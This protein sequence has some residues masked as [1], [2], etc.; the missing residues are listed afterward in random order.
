MKRYRQGEIKFILKPDGS[1]VTEADIEIQKF[2]IDRIRK[3]FPNSG[4][5]AEETLEGKNYS[6]NNVTPALGL[7]FVIDPIDG[8]GRFIELGDKNFGCAIALMY[9]GE[10][11]AATFYAPEYEI[12]SHSSDKYSGSLFEASE[13]CDGMFL[14]GKPVCM[15]AKKTNFNNHTAVLED[16]QEHGLNL[17]SLKVIHANGS[18][19]LT[20]SLVSSGLKDTPIVLANGGWDGSP[21]AYLWDVVAGAY[22]I[23]K[24][25]GV[26]WNR[27]GDNFFPL[28]NIA[29][30][31][32]KPVY[33]GEYFTGYPNAIKQLLGV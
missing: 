5:I 29:L 20:L 30:H 24:A 27:H 14:N 18:D 2:I 9:N 3:E 10:V 25:G 11:I 32:G 28:T 23:E 15:D 8:T 22:F 17:D 6:T 7:N 12:N 21:G 16:V 13:L 31:K 1:K 19:V 33:N 4:I 26:A